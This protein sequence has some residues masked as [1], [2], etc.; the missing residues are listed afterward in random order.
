MARPSY[1]GAKVKLLRDITTRGGTT[2]KAGVVMTVSSV[3]RKG[4]WL[5]CYVRGWL[6][7]VSQISRD[8]VKVIAFKQEE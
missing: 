6:Y 8:D 4:L 5:S 3:E 7:S 1:V 2:F